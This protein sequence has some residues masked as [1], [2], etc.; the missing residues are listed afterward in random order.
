MIRPHF[1]L[2][3]LAFIGQP[4]L[5][6]EEKGQSI[7]LT[8]IVSG[9]GTFSSVDLTVSGF[10][11]SLIDR[12]GSVFHFHIVP[13]NAPPRA[14]FLTVVNLDAI[15]WRSQAL[16]LTGQGPFLL[17]HVQLAVRTPF[18]GL[19]TTVVILTPREGFSLEVL[20]RAS[21]TPPEESPIASAVVTPPPP[22][23]SPVPTPYVWMGGLVTSN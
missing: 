6:P 11:V 15:M 22:T 23:S 10:L 3:F 17:H 19:G 5:W 20:P 14:D 18:L 21:P 7:S 4:A 1:L 12:T 8:T 16:A 13:N 9:P 2:F